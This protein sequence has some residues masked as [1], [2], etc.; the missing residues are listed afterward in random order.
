MNKVMLGA[1]T[2][3][4]FSLSNDHPCQ[5]GEGPH[6]LSVNGRSME[7][8]IGIREYVYSVCTCTCEL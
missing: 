5:L 2:T 7:N 4:L 3:L 1:W 8:Y 6:T